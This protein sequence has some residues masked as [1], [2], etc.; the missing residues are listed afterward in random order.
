MIL[1]I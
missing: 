1:Y